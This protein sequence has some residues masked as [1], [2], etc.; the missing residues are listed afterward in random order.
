MENEKGSLTE[1]GLGTETG[2]EQVQSKT[3]KAPVPRKPLCKVDVNGRLTT[4]DD[5]PLVPMRLTMQRVIDAPPVSKDQLYNQA[6]SN[7]GIT[8]ASWEEIWIKHVNINKARDFTANSIMKLFGSE[9]Y[10]PIICLGSG[11]SLKKNVME[12]KGREE[13]RVVS[14]LHNF[15]YLEDRDLMSKDDYYLTLDAGEITIPEV[16]QLKDTD[17]NRPDEWY[18][19][20]TKDRTLLAHVATHP[21]LLE[22]W[23]GPIYYFFTPLSSDKLTDEFKR[24]IDFSKVP[25]VQVGGNALGGCMYVAKAILGAGV[26]IFAGADFSFDYAHQFHPAASPYDKQ[27]SGIMPA[28]DIFGNRVYTWG[29]YFNFK[30]WMEYIAMGGKGN[31]MVLMINATEGG[32][33]GSY[34]EGNIQQIRQMGLKDAIYTFT[35][36]KSNKKLVE[37]GKE[38]LCLLF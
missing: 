10:K 11:P 1:T 7:D 3:I 31:N 6:A 28:T 32:I 15:A 34:P 16:T 30:N 5:V 36:Y 26:I 25:I 27:F 2:N 20:R 12:L 35:M 22:K 21:D 8:T 37:D 17:V 23:Q 29:S 33:M 4:L 38:K 24:N 18:W 13:I 9:A 19:G 14:C